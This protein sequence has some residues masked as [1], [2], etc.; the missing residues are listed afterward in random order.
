MSRQ[1]MANTLQSGGKLKM[2]MSTML[3]LEIRDELASRARALAAA[4]NRR[5][6]DAIL[7]WIGQA[8]ADPAIE[9]LSDREVLALCDAALGDSE[10]E[11]LSD[12]P[13]QLREQEITDVGRARLDE[14]MSSYRAG[15]VR[16]ARATKEA[17][18]R[19]LRPQLSEDAAR[20]GPSRC[21][22]P[23][24]GGVRHFT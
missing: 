11:E 1:T 23:G 2:I 5:V 20:T 9:S 24:R 8:V 6:E 15:M 13:T 19:G 18:S 12:L 22:P 17:V 14:L 3:T 10:Q 21:R 16:K 7:E 4:T